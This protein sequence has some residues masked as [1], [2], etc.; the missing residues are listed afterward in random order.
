MIN[1]AIIKPINNENRRLKYVDTARFIAMLFV[2]LCHSVSKGEIR[3]IGYSFHLPI[4]FILNGIT[5]K[6]DEDKPFG[7]FLEKKLKSYLIPAFC[8]GLLCAVAE[9]FMQKCFGIGSPKEANHIGTMLIKLLEQKRVYPIWFLGALLFSDIIF[10]F[11][12]KWSKNKFIPCGLL[13]LLTLAAAIYFN[14]YFKY[15]FAWNIDVA[16]FGVFFVGCGYLFSHSKST[17]VRDFLLSCKWISLLFGILLFAVGQVLGEINHYRYNV[18]LEMWAM[19]YE[20]YYLTLPCALLSSFG[21]ILTCNAISNNLFSWLGKATLVMLAFHQIVT[22]PLFKQLTFSWYQ[23]I[24]YLSGNDLRYLLYNITSMLF[25]VTILSL[26]HLLIIN[27][28]FAFIVN[29]KMPKYYSRFWLNIK[30]CFLR[31]R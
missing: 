27:S 5:L 28:P 29:K 4:F 15:R 8:L 25:S 1:E 24:A 21:V 10:Y 12:V 18:H 3:H 23:S 30:G 19:Q 20:K 17:K 7:I 31:K 13:S 16:L 9:I 26:V 22:I 14:K 11:I 2:I 6:I